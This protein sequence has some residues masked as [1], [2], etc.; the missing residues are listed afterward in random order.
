MKKLTLLVIEDEEAIRD[1]LRFSLPK[2]EFHLVDAENTS[3][4]FSML[5]HCIPDLIILDWMLP[6]KSGID[7]IKTIRKQD[8][9]KDIPV[10]ML[11]AKAEEEN[12]IKGLMVGADDYLTKPFSPNELAARI[13][14][15]L[16]RGL[17]KSVAGEVKLGK[18]VLNTNKCSV[19]IDS[20]PVR[21]TP[22]EYKILCFF[23]LHPDKIYTRDQLIT[24]VWG[25]NAYIDERTIDV[26]IKRLRHK[27][28]PHGYHDVIKTVRSAGYIFSGHNHVQ[29]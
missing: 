27:L 15:V 26:Q 14:T 16:R 11:T 18:L 20:N 2:D 10:I 21:L 7:F 29:T 24:H 22:A 23:M 25:R 19:F 8:V 4:A 9:H 6:D 13:R 17:I 12:K 3:K 1:M 5:S 28:K